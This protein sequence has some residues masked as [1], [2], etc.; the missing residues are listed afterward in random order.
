MQLLFRRE[1]CY[2][3]SRI[4]GGQEDEDYLAGKDGFITMSN[5][6]QQNQ[7]GVTELTFIAPS[8]DEITNPDPEIISERLIEAGPVYWEAGSGDAA[9]RRKVGP[10]V[11]SELIIVLRDN[12]G[13]FL[14][15]IDPKTSL[16][17]V[18]CDP[19]VEDEQIVILHA[20]DPWELPKRFFVTREVANQAVKWFIAHGD[21]SPDLTWE[22]F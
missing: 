21:R 4:N 2:L 6:S 7:A 22:V 12:A 18:L 9:L 3:A 19:N 17:F 15:F 11:D 16:E 20:G 8:G 1:R 13:V 5:E 10:N 14:Q